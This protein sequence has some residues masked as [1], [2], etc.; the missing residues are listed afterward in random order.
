M[1]SSSCSQSKDRGRRP[2]QKP[3]KARAD[4]CGSASMR[5]RTLALLVSVL[6]AVSACATESGN[7]ARVQSA[8]FVSSVRVL[9]APLLAD[10]ALQQCRLHS[11]RSRLA[12]APAPWGLNLADAKMQTLEHSPGTPHRSASQTLSVKSASARL[13]LARKTLQACAILALSVLPQ[14]P[15]TR[16]PGMAAFLR[17]E[18][19]CEDSPQV[20]HVEGAPSIKVEVVQEDLP[21]IFRMERIRAH[22]VERAELRR[23]LTGAGIVAVG[24]G[25]LGMAPR[26]QRRRTYAKG[27]RGARRAELRLRFLSLTPEEHKQYRR[28]YRD[29]QL[30]YHDERMS[31]LGVE[32]R[33]RSNAT[34]PD[35]N[36]CE[37]ENAESKMAAS[38]PTSDAAVGGADGC[39]Q[40]D[41]V[42][43]QTER[44]RLHARFSEVHEAE[45]TGA[46]AALVTAEARDSQIVAPDQDWNSAAEA[47][48]PREQDTASVGT[49]G[50][51]WSTHGEQEL[52]QQPVDKTGGM[53]A[54]QEQTESSETGRQEREER[55]K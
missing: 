6:A 38:R 17:I 20:L 7:R 23:L 36:T 28:G 33:P 16:S 34:P 31:L 48:T 10:V 52:L 43:A 1:Q 49:H 13:C 55:A 19:V 46:A 54:Q 44:R 39:L 29:L 24:G 26:L 45:L 2:E 50:G 42:A 18:V 9:G 15:S 40:I 30:A 47:N 12:R 8:A 51:Q 53:H 11:Q 32:V 3:G 4:M 25:M 35:L 5:C 41:L 21:Y 22:N 37:H 27:S 14:S